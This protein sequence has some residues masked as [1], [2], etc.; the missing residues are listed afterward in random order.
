MSA[1]EENLRAA[2]RQKLLA[3]GA[4]L[5]SREQRREY[6]YRA[7]LAGKALREPWPHG[8][9]PSYEIGTSN[10]GQAWIECKVCGLVSWH[11]KDVEE[12]YCG[13]CHQFHDDENHRGAM[14]TEL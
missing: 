10:Q 7:V 14:S 9:V 11:P 5:S 2:D 12:R 6:E 4:S 13:H 3:L 1:F 8:I